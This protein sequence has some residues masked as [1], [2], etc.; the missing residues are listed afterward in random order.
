L[1]RDLVRN[2][3]K[4]SF[5][6]S[7]L[8]AL[9]F[10]WSPASNAA[11][12]RQPIVASNLEIFYGVIPA[13]VLLGHPAEQAERTMHGGVPSRNAY[14]LVVSLFDA[15]TRERVT[16]ARVQASVSEAR[17]VPQT[18]PLQTMVLAGAITY[19]N[20]FSMSGPGPFR[21]TLDVT[22]PHAGPPVKVRF[23]YRNQ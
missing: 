13:A 11:E 17:L 6:R 7:T 21:V 15:K 14:H 20:Y 10:L 3:R 16:D 19:G 8:F 2:M 18:K 12:V 23:E 5:I 22:R 4:D 9:A 1:R